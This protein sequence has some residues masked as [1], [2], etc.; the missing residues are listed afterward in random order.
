M[1]PTLISRENNSA[2][3]SMAF[4]AEEFESAI[5]EAYKATRGKFAI[6]GFRKGKAPRK[7][8]ETRFGEDIFYEEAINRLFSDN[9]TVA[10]D[11]LNLEV[12]NRPEAEFGDIDKKEGFTVT[13]TVDVYPD[14]EIKDYKGVAIDRADEAV[15]E[16]EL[17]KE[18][19]ALR[20]RNSRMVV[21]ERPAQDGDTVLI[22]YAGFIG[23]EQ[24]EGGTAERHPLK[25]GTG[26]FIP[27]FEEQLIG[28]TVGEEKDIQ[29]TF[30]EEYHAEDLAGKD[31]VF[32]CK[33]HEI[34]EEELPELNDEF[35]KD[36]SEH[37]T[38]AEF[39]TAKREQMERVAKIAAE[40]R[41]KT[42]AVEKIRD[43]SEV[44]VPGGMLEDEIDNMMGEF[45]QQ[46]RYQGM[47]LDM[48]FAYTQKDPLEFRNEMRPEAEKKVKT[49]MVLS[50]IAEQEKIEVTDEEIEAELEAITRQYNLDPARAEETFTPAFMNY[51]TKD[52]KMKKAVELIF[53]NA[54]IKG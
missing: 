22:D 5:V 39:K 31:A 29:V 24:F 30:P 19:D 20:K 13:I 44:G 36:V 7:L 6:D 4:S 40:N 33:V 21:V 28:V 42:A 43:A 17:D 54:K 34:K 46:L 2:K 53:S 51:V 12:V 45:D 35:A 52:I 49:R 11:E 9:Y 38:L 23:D 37:D 1:K 14:F 27:G 32:K 41:M 8:I 50:K 3:F 47:S 10:L 48:Y 26:A 25:L 15:S 18:M 16:E